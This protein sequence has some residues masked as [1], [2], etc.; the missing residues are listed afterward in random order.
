MAVVTAK[1]TPFFVRSF[2]H[3]R[4]GKIIRAENYGKKAF[5]IFGKRKKK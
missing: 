2:K 4:S 5:P 3:W 1:G